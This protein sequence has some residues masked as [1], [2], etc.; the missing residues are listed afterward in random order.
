MKD[1]FNKIEKMANG[2]YFSLSYKITNEQSKKKWQVCGVYIDGFNWHC[3]ETW[4]KAIDSI[5]EEIDNEPDSFEFEPIE[6]IHE[7]PF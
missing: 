6:N 4:Q 7:L 1:A 2:R 3:R 5:Q